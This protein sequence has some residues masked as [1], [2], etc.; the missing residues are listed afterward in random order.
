F[1]PDGVV[2]P[3]QTTTD[4]DGDGLPDDVE[5]GAGMDPNSSDKEV[6][7]AV[8]KYFFS[9]EGGAAKSL[10]KA[11]PYTYSWYYQPEMGWMWTE[12]SIFPYIFKSSS[13]G[14]SGSWMYFSEQSANPI[15]MY[16]YSLENWLT[17]GE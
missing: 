9:Q 4:S 14:Q 7:D 5:I 8:Y 17:L 12:K 3:P 11:K 16:D 10:E 6:I 13:N 1:Y 2:Q 15:K